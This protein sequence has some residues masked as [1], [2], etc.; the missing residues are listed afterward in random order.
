MM[1]IMLDTS[2]LISRDK[3]FLAVETE[4]PEILTPEAFVNSFDNE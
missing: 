3:D 4:R 1:R 2:V